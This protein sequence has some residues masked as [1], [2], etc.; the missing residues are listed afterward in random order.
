MEDLQLLIWSWR[1]IDDEQ[2]TGHEAILRLT[3]P[4]GN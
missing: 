1:C 4:E 2:T 3:A